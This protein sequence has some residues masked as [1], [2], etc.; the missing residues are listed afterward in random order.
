[1]IFKP[2]VIPNLLSSTTV[3]ERAVRAGTGQGTARQHRSSE[4]RRAGTTGS[5][6]GS[7]RLTPTGASQIWQLFCYK[8]YD[9][10]I[11]SMFVNL[12]EVD[13][14]Q[15]QPVPTSSSQLHPDQAHTCLSRHGLLSTTKQTTPSQMHKPLQSQDGIR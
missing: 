1:M 9:Q 6:K 8:P 12:A 15:Q 13:A 11:R 3:E 14:R 7:L 2:V 5:Q 10:P 4:S